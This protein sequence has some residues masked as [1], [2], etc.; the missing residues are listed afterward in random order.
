M[1]V[2][3]STNPADWYAADGVYIAEQDAPRSPRIEGTRFLGVVGEFPWGPTNELVEVNEGSDLLTKLVGK[4]SRPQDY[5]GYRALAGKTMGKIYAVRVEGT[6]M[7]KA[8]ATVGVGTDDLFTATAKHKGAV[9]NE[10]LVKLLVGSTTSLFG[11]EV[12]WG[13]DIE[14]F[15]D[16]PHGSTAFDDVE[17]K[18]LDFT[19][20]DD[21]TITLPVADGA[22]VPFTGGADG[23]FADLDYTGSTSEI[24]GLRILENMPDGGYRFFAE[25]TSAALITALRAHVAIT[26]SEGGAQASSSNVFT[27]NRDA[28]A[29]IS[30]D[31][32]DL[33]GVRVQQTINGEVFT[34][35]FV[36][37]VASAWSQIPEHY[38]VADVDNAD[39]F[40]WANS[41]APGVTIGRTE[42]VEANAA[43]LI[44]LAPLEGGGFKIASGITSDP[45]K[46]SMI[47]RRMELF[48]GNNCGRVL[49]PFQNKPATNYYV[50][51]AFAGLQGMF[52]ALKGEEQIPQTQYIEAFGLEIVE[53]TGSSVIFRAQVKLWGELRFIILNLTV[54]EDLIITIE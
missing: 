17:S 51:G 1:T 36:P 19:Y 30:D 35:D 50:D 54:G 24:K 40:L 3:R 13:D 29:L 38:S 8:S 28:A 23:T 2:F 18:Y 20:D 48:I 37:G 34:V 11:V 43:G 44:V 33:V 15:E 26:G 22:Y 12:K 27:D 16:L 6:G 5:K 32:I 7:A 52:E 10:I 39:L 42:R 4:A 25:H 45:N 31:G 53:K 9:G 14:V 46:P 41:L 21:G 49:L 47:T